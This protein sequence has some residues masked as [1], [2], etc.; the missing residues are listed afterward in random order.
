MTDTILAVRP[1]PIC[2]C[3][4]DVEF[5]PI[6]HDV[7][8]T[9]T[10][11][12]PLA[13]DKLAIV[14]EYRR[15]KGL[16]AAWDLKHR[17]RAIVSAQG[18]MEAIGNVAQAPSLAVEAVGWVSTHSDKSWDLGDVQARAQE[19]LTAR[20]KAQELARKTKCP[21]C[22]RPAIDG[23]NFC[24]DHSWCRVC[25]ETIPHGKSYDDSTYPICAKCHV[26]QKSCPKP[27]W[28]K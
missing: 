3:S 19:F 17:A 21:L 22:G 12:P 27:G 2:G 4:V 7:R 18:I 23:G 26:D 9:T 14:A 20:T 1:C 24:P 5:D 6:S 15:I 16:G 11:L 25:D 13:K 10:D 8:V 28:V